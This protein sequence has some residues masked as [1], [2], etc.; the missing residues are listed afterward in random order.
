[1]PYTSPVSRTPTS[2]ATNSP[3]S[4]RRSSCL[5]EPSDTTVPELPRSSSY[6][7]RHRRS[8]ST[9]ISC[10]SSM[11]MM[12]AKIKSDEGSDQNRSLRQSPSPVTSENQIPAGVI[13]SPPES[14]NNSSDDETWGND[15]ITSNKTES[16]KFNEFQVTIRAIAQN[17]KNATSK[18]AKELQNKL[19]SAF[20]G[21]SA[22]IMKAEKSE[23]N[24][25]LAT[26]AHERTLH[27][28]RYDERINRNSYSPKMTDENE[29]KISD[30]VQVFDDDQEFMEDGP[31]LIPACSMIRKK[32]GELVRPALRPSIAR[33]RPSSMPG[34][35]TFS[36]AVH[37]D[38]Q[39]EHIRHFLQVD[40][41]LAVS[42]GSSPVPAYDS[43]N[44]FPFCEAPTRESPYQWEI[45]LS[46]FPSETPLRLAQ[47]VRVERVF[48]SYDNETLVGS[49]VVANLAFKKTVVVRFTL[50]YWRTTSE[51]V[52][53]FN[54]DI[55]QPT[56]EGYD[57]FNFNVKLTDQ[58]N[59]EAKTMF[60]CVKYCVNGVEYWDNN[61][62]INF[63]V[64]FRKKMKTRRDLKTW[65]QTER[66]SNNSLP[67]SNFR[68][69]STRPNWRPIVFED[70][71]DG[72]EGKNQ[73]ADFKQAVDENSGEFSSLRLKGP[74]SKT[75]LS[76][77]SQLQ[78]VGQP[79]GNAFGN[80][81]DFG[82]SLTAAINAS[83][84]PVLECSPMKDKAQTVRN[85][86]DEA[87]SP[88]SEEPPEINFKTSPS[89]KSTSPETSRPI[90]DKKPC[91]SSQSYNDLLDK[92]CFFGSTKSSQLKDGTFN[93][94]LLTTSDQRRYQNDP[95]SI[96]TSKP[97]KEIDE[98]Y[99]SNDSDRMNQSS[100]STVAARF[101]TSIYPSYQSPHDGYHFLDSHSATAIRG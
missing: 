29:S 48:L 92:Y 67:R 91:L 61:N 5:L 54:N 84:L 17:R 37:F 98:F 72:F 19:A 9:K 63:Q 62:S 1:M 65:P 55:R 16:E 89:S 23:K 39:L 100:S 52:A 86:T 68:S 20:P 41:P 44:E 94:C 32:S 36:K 4:S 101:G 56:R 25:L 57:R 33:R 2:S 88:L 82:V 10:N 70:Y 14:T 64:D 22:E 49:V 81:Y 76:S 95:K 43:D 12:K 35:P 24:N 8:G 90:V 18:D 58:A 78:K 46:N 31:E 51:V 13:V 87:I 80:R 83:N 30:D 45:V 99:R 71:A 27:R 69:A 7:T 85:D 50:D 38:S 96:H 15:R 93:S 26:V 75:V 59:L 60:F 42:A 79:N 53:E 77:N 3:C 47:P 97:Q 28:T 6:L 74:R 73:L 40:R 66:L 11:E 21:I 34:T